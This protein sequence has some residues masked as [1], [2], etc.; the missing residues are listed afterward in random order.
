MT[1]FLLKEWSLARFYSFR[2]FRF[3]TVPWIYAD[4]GQLS[5]TANF[6]FNNFVIC[7]D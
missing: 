2:I 5:N 1:M 7:S 3:V 6:K 4:I